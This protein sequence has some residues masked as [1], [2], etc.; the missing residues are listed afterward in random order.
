MM[1]IIPRNTLSYLI[2]EEAAV[3]YIKSIIVNI[4]YLL[5]NIKNLKT[6]KRNKNLQILEEKFEDLITVILSFIGQI[7]DLPEPSEKNL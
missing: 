6:V 4:K 7:I 3:I 1:Y 5:Q 2:E